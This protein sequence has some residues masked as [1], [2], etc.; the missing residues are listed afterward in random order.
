L[1]EFRKKN[2]EV[3]L[4]TL[5]KFKIPYQR[6][7]QHFKKIETVKT[8]L[9]KLKIILKTAELIDECILNFYT[10]HKIPHNKKLKY[11]AD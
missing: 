1:L 7:I 3:R 5:H 10:E 2:S 4:T 8:P 9:H 11:D 6:V